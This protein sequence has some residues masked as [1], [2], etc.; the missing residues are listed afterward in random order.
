M[1]SPREAYYSQL[2]VAETVA[3]NKALLGVGTDARR[4]PRAGKPRRS[5]GGSTGLVPAPPLAR[6]ARAGHNLWPGV[7][8]EATGPTELG[9]LSGRRCQKGRAGQHPVV[10]WIC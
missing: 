7:R 9:T 2:P 5:P 6:A 10:R 1:F 4:E 3:L 8:G